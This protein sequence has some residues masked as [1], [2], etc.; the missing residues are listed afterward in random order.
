MPKD[1]IVKANNK[2]RITASVMGVLLGLSGILNHG[3]FEILQG[4]K[5]MNGFF[6]EAISEAHRFWIHGTETAFTII[7]NYLATGIAVVLTGLAVVYWS[8]KYIHTKNGPTVFILLMILLTLVGGGI[9]YVILFVP[10]WAFATRVNSSLEWWERKLPPQLRRSLS[11]LWFYFLLAT[12]AAWLIVM[13]MGI[14]GYFPG[15]EYP[16]TILNIVFTFVFLSVFLACVT[17]ICA[18]A[19]DIEEKNSMTSHST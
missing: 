2:T 7:H 15:Q 6:I 11:A 19:G 8:I 5:P 1:A 10:T 9:G 3:L 16:D 18:Y 4:N 13:E 17:F 14:F 12:S